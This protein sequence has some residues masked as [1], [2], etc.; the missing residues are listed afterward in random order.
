M[1]YGHLQHCLNDLREDTICNADDT[2][3]YTRPEPNR[4]TGADGQQRTCRD[5]AALEQWAHKHTACFTF[6]HGD[7][8]AWNRTARLR[9]CPPDSPYLPKIRDYFGFAADWMPEQQT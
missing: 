4:I 5:F 1:L 7:D 6:A 9:F 3:R 2:P 8:P